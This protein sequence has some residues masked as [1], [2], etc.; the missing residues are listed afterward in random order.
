MVVRAEC[1]AVVNF[2]DSVKV[3]LSWQ[4]APHLPEE[5]LWINM[6]K[7]RMTFVQSKFYRIT[8]EEGD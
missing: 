2:G 5:Y 8:I 4:K 1:R 7:E 3:L 6:L